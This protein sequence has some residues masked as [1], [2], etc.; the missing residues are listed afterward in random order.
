MLKRIPKIQKKS[1]DY[2]NVQR[3]KPLCKN[4]VIIQ[5]FKWISRQEEILLLCRCSNEKP[6]GKN[7][8]DYANLCSNKYPIEKILVIMHYA[9]AH[10]SRGKVAISY[11]IVHLGR[12]ERTA[13]MNLYVAY[14][15][16]YV[17]IP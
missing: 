8:Y 16:I 10:N 5:L 3:T 15:Y 4:L 17:V 13:K 7:Y 11:L 9:K 2:A 12:T 6:I 14:L 1:Y